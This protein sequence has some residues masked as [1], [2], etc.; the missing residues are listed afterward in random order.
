MTAFSLSF[1]RENIDTSRPALIE[2]KNSF[3]KKLNIFGSKRF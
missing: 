1:G 2:V 3:M